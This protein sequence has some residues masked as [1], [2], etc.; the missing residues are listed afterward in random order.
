MS[1]ID[2]FSRKLWI[3][4]LKGKDEAFMRFKEWCIEV[5][6]EKDTYLM[7]KN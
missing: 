6:T 2:D 4:I 5:E 1:I 3:Y 7:L